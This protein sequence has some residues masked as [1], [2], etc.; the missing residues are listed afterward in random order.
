MSCKVVTFED[1]VSRG[2]GFVQFDSEDCANAAI[3]NLN[4]KNVGGKQ[5]YVISINI[6]Y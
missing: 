3:E 4:G 6:L 1:G 2:F 5:M